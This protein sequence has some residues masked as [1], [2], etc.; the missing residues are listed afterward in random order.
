MSPDKADSPPVVVA[1]AGIGGLCAA[2]ALARAGHE[3]LLLDKAP[4]LLEAGAGLQMSPNACSVLFSLGVMEAL[5][6]DAVAPANLQIRSGKSGDLLAKVRLGDFIAERHGNPFWVIHRADLQRALLDTVQHTSGITLQ[7]GAE[8]VG[9]DT[10]PQDALVCR[11][12]SDEDLHNLRCKALIGADGV[13]S[14]VRRSIP[15]HRIASFSGHIA[16][17]ATIPMDKLPAARWSGDSGLWLHKDSH[18]VHYPIRGGRALNVVALARASWEDQSWSA[19]ADK[20]DLLRVFANW[21][22]EV[23]TLLGMPDTWLKWALGSVDASGPWVH[24]RIA[25]LGDAAHAMLPFM[26]QGAATAIEDAAVLARHFTPETEY[27][28]AALRAY[29]RHRKARTSRIQ[30]LSFR[31]ARIFHL[32]GPAAMARDTVLRL[33][34]PERL[35]AKFD[36]IYGWT[37]DM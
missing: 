37:T 22:A 20:Q 7:L 3:I 16:Y 12:R 27:I 13:W 28:P 25:L 9:V 10:S 24:D 4:E 34:T 35:A 23:R 33:S 11:V 29:E 26:A 1:G 15:D 32:S 36:D 31:N 6:P 18:L 14:K 17:R 8:V 2:L 30:A 5:K 19:P 21:P